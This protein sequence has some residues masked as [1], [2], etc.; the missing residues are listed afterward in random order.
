MKHFAATA[1]GLALLG[2]PAFADGHATGDAEAGEKVFNKCKACHSIVDA[3]GEAIVK[4]GR[5]G[6][7]LYG[8]Y[9]RV[10]GTEDFRYG[11]SLVEAG[12][13][14]LEWNEEEFVAYVADPKKYLAEYLDDKKA[15]SKM[16]FKLR[17]DED[18]ADVWAYLVSVGPEVEAEA[19]SG[20]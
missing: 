5:N 12:E 11:D 8:L 14:G 20:S 7:N 17:G 6:P 16:S 9:T 13:A 10:A 18:A 4:G 19:D 3:D 2:A 1:L 15:R